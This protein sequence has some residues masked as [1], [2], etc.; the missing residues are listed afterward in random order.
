MNIGYYGT[1]ELNQALYNRFNNIIEIGE[2]SDK[3]IRRMLISRVSQCEP[4][5]E[6]I[7]SV[8]NKIKRKIE[9]EELDMVISPRNLENWAKLAKYEGYVSAAEKTIIPIAKCDRIFEETIRSIIVLY[10]WKEEQKMEYDD[11]EIL[12]AFQSDYNREI[13]ERFVNM[14]C[15]TEY[16]KLFFINENEAFIDGRNQGLLKLMNQR[17]IPLW[18]LTVRGK[19]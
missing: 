5:V 4:M 16:L 13:E 6:K 12:D 9:N 15:D 2:L 18:I 11:N 1:R 8:F 3:S 19:K 14:L 17:M 10:K 7:I